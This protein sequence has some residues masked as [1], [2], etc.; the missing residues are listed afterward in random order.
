MQSN[1]VKVVGS[2]LFVCVMNRRFEQMPYPTPS[3]VEAYPFVITDDERRSA[4]TGGR[5]RLFADAAF[6]PTSRPKP[7]NPHSYGARAATSEAAKP[8]I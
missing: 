8:R 2:A 6:W 5:L 7:A 4:P 1:Y 3:E